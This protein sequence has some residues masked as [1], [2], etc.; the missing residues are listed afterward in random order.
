MPVRAS[1]NDVRKIFWLCFAANTEFP[2]MERTVR[3]HFVPNSSERGIQ[4]TA[5]AVLSTV[6]TTL[7]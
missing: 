2:N 3:T 4:G 6:G 1:E 5:K 7:Q